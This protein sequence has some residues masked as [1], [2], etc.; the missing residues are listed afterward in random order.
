MAFLFD[1]MKVVAEPSG[2]VARRGAPRGPDRREGRPC[3]RDRLGRQRRRRPLRRAARRPPLERRRGRREPGADDVHEH[4]LGCR[5]RVVAV[6][7]PPEDPAGEQLVDAAVEDDRRPVASRG[8]RG[9]PRLPGRARRCAGSRRS[10]SR[11]RRSAAPPPGCARSRARGRARRPARAATCAGE[12]PR[13]DGAAR[14][15]ARRTPRRRGS[16][17]PGRPV[18]AED[19]LEHLV[20]R[21]EVVVEQAVRDSGLLRDVAH[22]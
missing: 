7:Q 9:T 3:R 18:L 13:R 4:G 6:G 14:A 20:L 11:A 22:A 21:G 8:R 12:S 17:R 15:R 10:A 19:R 5:D 1:R 16:A 2:A